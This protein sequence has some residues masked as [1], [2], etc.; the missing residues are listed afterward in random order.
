MFSGVVVGDTT[1]D[2]CSRLT[3]PSCCRV[4]GVFR[5]GAGGRGRIRRSIKGGCD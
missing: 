3:S 5:G 4:V 2:T 1:N